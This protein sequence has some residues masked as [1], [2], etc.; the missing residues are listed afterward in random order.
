MTFKR[1]ANK[2][3]L[4]FREIADEARLPENEVLKQNVLPIFFF[5]FT[6]ITFQS[7]RHQ[8]ELLVMK[9]LSL[10]LVKGTIDQ[11]D[12][13]VQITWVQPRVL[14]KEQV[15]FVCLSMKLPIKSNLGSI[16]SC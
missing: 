11:V 8:V 14:D 13:K 5:T 15:C 1:E 3:Q 10:D 2:R 12:Q 6:L 16:F 7:L 9:A 4:S